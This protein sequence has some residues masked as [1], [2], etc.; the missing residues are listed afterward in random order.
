MRMLFKTLTVFIFIAIASFSA[1]AQTVTPTPES[2]AVAITPASLN[3]NE[4]YRIGF[5][6]TIEVQ[7]F[8]QPKL[9]QR[10]SVNPNGTINLFR[11]ADPIVAVCKTERELSDAIAAAYE[12]DYLRDPQVN[13]VV[14]DQRSQSFAV[15]GAVE[16]P[17]NYFIN[18]KVRLL[19]LLAQAGGP[20]KEA[21]SRLV[22]ARTGSTSDCKLGADTKAADDDI[23][24]LDFKM[25]DVLQAK[26]DLVMQPGDIVSVMDSD[27]IYVYGNVNKQGQVEIK[28]PITLTQA[29]AS[30]EGLKPATKKDS[31]RV[32]RQK[33]GTLER[34][35]FVYSLNDIENRK[36]Q[37]PFL[38]PNDIVAV[39]DDKVKGFLRSIKTSLTQGIPS[40]IY[41]IP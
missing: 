28:E 7:V 41:R 20:T 40:I 18:R 32:F 11:L 1:L 27:V 29:I 2:T 26:S 23:E 39:D 31:I 17:G 9:T 19:E 8:G 34:D 33:P 37:D 14:V 35:E 36:V 24:L 12:K 13:A 30:A 4:R 3:G 10:V 16:K 38:E 15:I 25:S 21:G 5:Q 22:V 6:D